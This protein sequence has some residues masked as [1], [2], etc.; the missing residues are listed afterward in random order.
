[1]SRVFL[2][3]RRTNSKTARDLADDLAPYF[4]HDGVF[5]DVD[6][7]RPGSIFASELERNLGA[8][9]VV[10]VVIASDW[11][12]ELQRRLALPDPDY[13]RAEI[14]FA[15][16]TP[17]RIVPVLI[18]DATLP[19]A[20][21]LPA[22]IAPLVERQAVALRRTAWTDDI[23]RL[24][25]GIGRPY[26]WRCL[27]LRGLVAVPTI[28]VAVWALLRFFPEDTSYFIV[29]VLVGALVA[30]YLAMEWWIATRK[31]DIP[32]V[33]GSATE[34]HHLVPLPGRAGGEVP[35]SASS[36]PPTPGSAI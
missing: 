30:F 21:D 24:V 7:I 26:C 14:A 2:S 1:M 29:R 25:D 4:G 19:I 16:H 36:S 23:E 31:G 20:A 27:L 11:C 28:L 12:K 6:D 3:Y 22:D 18:D 35:P 13:V 10:V 9:D 15:L 33:A 34:M 17:A 5:L 32:A 8:A